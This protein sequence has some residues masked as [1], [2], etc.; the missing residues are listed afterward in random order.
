MGSSI[1]WNGFW[2]FFLSEDEKPPQQNQTQKA[3]QFQKERLPFSGLVQCA[4]FEHF[5]PIADK[6]K[7]ISF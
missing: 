1:C 7:S 2:L 5:F 6:D 3:N 4:I